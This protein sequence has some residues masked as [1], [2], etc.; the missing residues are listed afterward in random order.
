MDLEE[1][2]TVDL[3]AIVH[4]ACELFQPLA[5]DKSI[6][7][8]FEINGKAQVHC[9]Q[10]MLQRM[11]ANLVDNAIKYT[12]AGGH[13]HVGL[14]I[15]DDQRVVLTVADDGAGIDEQD[16]PRIFHRFFRGDQSRTIGGAGL[17]LSFVQA[18]VHAHGG[19][20]QVQSKLHMGTLF[21]IAL[22]LSIREQTS[23][24][25]EI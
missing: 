4:D 20:I 10:R 16:L 8:T 14:R 1:C 19:D 18:A 15:S 24:A 22:P 7:L 5:E 25:S 3:S 6:E 17:G 23:I 12:A 11:V 13:I 2:A 21:T 9:D